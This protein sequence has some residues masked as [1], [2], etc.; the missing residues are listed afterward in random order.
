MADTGYPTVQ[1]LIDGQW[2][3]G[4]AAQ[5]HDVINP[6]TQAVIGRYP[7]ASKEDIDAALTSARKAQAA[8]RA[9]SPQARTEI[10]LKAS[11]LLRERSAQIAE[12]S[13]LELGTPLEDGRNYVL[14]AAD[15]L[16]W[17]A[18]EGR[19]LY[20]RVVPSPDG[21]RQMVVPEPIGAVAA[22]SP[23]NAP[24]LTPCRKIGSALAAG[25]VIVL[26]AAEETPACAMAVIQAFIDAG[27]PAGTI[28][29]LF[30]NPALVSETLIA[31]PVIRMVTFTGSVAVGKHLAQLAAAQMKP[32]LM[33]LGGHAPVIV[34]EDADVEDAA[35][36]CAVSKFRNTGQACIAPTRFFVH[37]S[38][39]DRFKTVFVERTRAQ[40][41][42]VP[43]QTGVAMGPY[44]NARRRDQV[45][46]LIREAVARGAV[47]LHGGKAI[48]ERG[49]FYEPTVLTDV[50]ETAR[51]MQEEPFGA[52]ACLNRYTDLKRVIA[53]ANALP[54]GLA[55]YVFT[56]S[57][58][59]ADYLARSLEC[60]A[61]AINHLT[62]ST[63]GIPFGGVKDSGIGREGGSEGVRNYTVSKT[64]TH[65][66]D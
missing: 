55:G 16:E 54:Y 31:S 47:L 6:S 25:C 45:D 5:H 2:T 48:G 44:A 51:I 63:V 12:I 11:Q 22:F 30:G 13:A 38:V 64:I 61:V 18:H 28:N 7:V 36:R 62:V 58:A 53:Q 21:M 3:S 20:G 9:A 43:T 8:W 15:I 46:G 59:T 57:A 4:N 23:W 14:R 29:L 35:S 32:V 39:F 65:R 19:R 49:F 41:I 56:R 66:M 52:V 26:K 24:V 17:D 1:F 27:A 50:P 34:C 33:E 37:D 10:V 40:K 42:G 60:G